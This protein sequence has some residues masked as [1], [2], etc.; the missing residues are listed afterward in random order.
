MHQFERVTAPID[1][2]Y[3]ASAYSA[4]TLKNWYESSH[5]VGYLAISTQVLFPVI[6]TFSFFIFFIYTLEFEP[7]NLGKKLN[8]ELTS[9]DSKVK[10]R[11][12]AKLWTKFTISAL[13]HLCI[14]AADGGARSQYELLPDKIS[15]Y[16]DAN[17]RLFWG[18]PI[19]MIVFDVLTILLFIIGPIVVAMCTKKWYILTYCLIA[20]LSCLASHSYHIIFAFI[21]DPF[22]ATSILLLYGIVIFVHVQGFQKM[23]YLMNSKWSKSNI[24]CFKCCKSRYPN[25]CKDHYTGQYLTIVA[26]H[27]VEFILMAGSI[28]LSLAFLIKLPISSAIDEAPNRLYV[29]YQASVTFFAAL[30]AFQ[31]LFRETSSNFDV[32]IKAIDAKQAEDK[33]SGPN[34]KPEAET[35]RSEETPLLNPVDSEKKTKD[36]KELSDKEKEFYLARCLMS[37]LKNLSYD[38]LDVLGTDAPPSAKKNVVCSQEEGTNEPPSAKKNVDFC[39]KCSSQTCKCSKGE[40]SEKGSHQQEV[41]EDIH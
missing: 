30:V 4:K 33:N 36:W 13:F 7:Y 20:P 23:F 41:E 5:E 29:I 26:L 19:E 31:L 12:N 9:K 24:D 35:R 6:M 38:E 39:Q 22:H 25:H 1:D 14:L 17:P 15:D 34:Y 10:A 16:Y 11:S 21:N 28:S 37:A 8:N 2:T 32:F 3:T 18:V 40:D 27:I